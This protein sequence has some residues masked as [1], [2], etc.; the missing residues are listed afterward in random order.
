MDHTW[1][2]VS[3]SELLSLMII[4]LAGDPWSHGHHVSSLTPLQTLLEIAV[5]EQLVD[6]RH[7][8]GFGWA[9]AACMIGQTVG[10]CH[11]IHLS[12]ASE[13]MDSLGS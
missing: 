13:W 12:H 3:E 2:P 4:V 5:E 6:G 1:R 9:L 11:C 10:P 7:S 8:S